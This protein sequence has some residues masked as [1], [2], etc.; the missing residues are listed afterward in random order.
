[1]TERS[2]EADGITV[3]RRSPRAVFALLGDDTRVG[4]LEALGATPD[5]SVPFAELH[6]R[7]GIRDS[8]QFNYHL[9][10]LRGSFVRRT[11][12]GYELTHAGRQIV[13]AMHA[14]TYTANATVDPIPT[15][16]DCPICGGR[17]VASYAA[18]T[19][20]VSCDS[21]AAWHNA[22]AFPPG[23]LDQYRREELPGAFDRWMK[24]VV[25]GIVDGFCYTCAGRM[26]GRLVVEDRDEAFADVPAAVAY[27]CE[28]CGSEARISAALPAHFHPAVQG[29]LYE[30]G[31]DTT[32]EP[33]WSL[34]DLADPDLTLVSAD[35][36]RL[37]VRFAGDEESLV[38]GLDHDASVGWLER[39]PRA[40]SARRGEVTLR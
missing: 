6:R 33:T 35:P 15:G 18:E 2:G 4:I 12:D 22:F 24:H 3:E 26:R 9:G 5:E 40:A 32:R 8:G 21:C 31:A 34:A 7:V 16:A 36:P 27:E 13:G 1:M 30:H 17:V 37:L 28:R 29:F 25:R 14:G 11:D 19:A 38:V 23:V 10:K 39:R 20:R